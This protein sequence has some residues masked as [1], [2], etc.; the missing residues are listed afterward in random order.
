MALWVGVCV[1]VV[2]ISFEPTLNAIQILF[3]IVWEGSSS[4]AII[5][6]AYG[7]QT[8]LGALQYVA[9]LECAQKH[10][11]GVMI[12]KALNIPS[13]SPRVAY[14]WWETARVAAHDAVVSVLWRRYDDA[15]DEIHQALDLLEHFVKAN[16][17]EKILAVN[18]VI[19]LD[20]NIQLKLKRALTKLR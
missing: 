20:P 1:C 19:I 18:P 11:A 10:Y 4:C 7:N 8:T 6:R 5:G 3:R 17:E 14:D 15:I 12:A 13:L 2:L 16:D 9:L